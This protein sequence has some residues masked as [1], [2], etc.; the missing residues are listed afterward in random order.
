MT[1]VKNYLSL[2][3]FSHTIFAMPFAMIGFFLGVR[4]FNQLTGFFSQ[5]NYELMIGID[6]TGFPNTTAEVIVR[7]CLV[8]LC[9]ITARSAAMAF[10]L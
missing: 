9:M 5:R 6:T 4:T 8:L 7:F 1:S 2:V 10:K 3:K